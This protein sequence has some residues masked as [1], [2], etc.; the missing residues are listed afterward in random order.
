M[1]ENVANETE[2][3]MEGIYISEENGH[4]E[5]FLYYTEAEKEDGDRPIGNRLYKYQFVNGALVDRQWTS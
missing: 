3:G 2:S 1:D 4:T 5:V